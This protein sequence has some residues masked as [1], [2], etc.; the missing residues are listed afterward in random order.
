MTRAVGEGFLLA[1]VILA[2]IPVFVLFVE[3]VAA[4][5][6][7][8]SAPPAPSAPGKGLVVLIPA[9]NEEAGIAGTLRGILPQ[10]EAGD[11]VIV[12]ADNCADQTADRARAGGAEVLER[13]H[14]TERGKGFALAHGLR[15]LKP[16]PPDLILFV[17]ADTAVDA[18]SI[19][20]LRRSAS[21]ARRPVQAVYLLDPPPAAGATDFISCFA[22]LVKN[23]VRPAGLARIGVPC[24][25]LGSGMAIP[26]SLIDIDRLATG[27]IVEDMQLGID[28]A[29]AG[30]PPMFCLQARVTGGLP[31]GRKAALVQR[32]RW[33]HG[34]LGTLISQ[35][36][37]LAWQALRQGRPALL[38]MALDLAVPP[39]ALVCLLWLLV[40]AAAAIFARRGFSMVPA[41][42]AA[43]CGAMLLLSV[44]LAWVR[45]ARSRIPGHVLL[46]APLYILW[47]IPL[48][49]A[50][51]FRRQKEWV[52]T[53][54]DETP[55]RAGKDR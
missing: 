55:T 2:G 16:D 47:K 45:H 44:F 37:R 12:V 32:T 54:R 20:A 28:L 46:F 1:A 7:R 10:L 19:A 38:G 51:L 31:A 25:L 40:S 3:C 36:P 8:R 6:P 22:F 33:E 18:G 34:H 29:V 5:W 4:L 9:H 23:L 24:Q 39:L 27:N 41:I 21:A 30:Q 49:L 52:R 50:F 35:S 26:W 13:R 48:Y 53:S 15:H 17:D 14:E 42:V 43:A 11:R